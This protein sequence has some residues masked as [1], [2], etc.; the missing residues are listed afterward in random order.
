[1]AGTQPESK[2]V[3]VKC[4]ECGNEQD[5]FNKPAEPVKCTVCNEV[6]ADN[7]GGKANIKAKVLKE[8]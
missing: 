3:K 4:E 6:L 5:I 7:T 1:M 8:H 2:F